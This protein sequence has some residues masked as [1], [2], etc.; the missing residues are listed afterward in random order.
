MSDLLELEK[1]YIRG[2]PVVTAK[3]QV[4]M[5][6]FVEL[7]EAIVKEIN[8]GRPRVIL[9]LHAINFIDSACLGMMLR[10]LDKAAEVGGTLVLV[11]NPFIDRVLTVTGLTHLFR[12]FRSP[13]EAANWLKDSLRQAG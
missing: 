7:H 8:E 4:D 13:Q 12:I 10:T 11:G 1:S 3:G 9:D 2:L 5:A 6:N